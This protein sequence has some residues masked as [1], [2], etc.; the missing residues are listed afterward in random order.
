MSRKIV[1]S[2]SAL[3]LGV[4]KKLLNRKFLIMSLLLSKS[5]THISAYSFAAK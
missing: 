4:A 2:R 1:N 5:A 3:P